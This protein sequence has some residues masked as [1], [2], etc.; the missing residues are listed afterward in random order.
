MVM[1]FSENIQNSMEYANHAFKSFGSW[2]VLI[3]LYAVMFAGT[4]LLIVGTIFMLTTLFAVLTPEMSSMIDPA[5]MMNGPMMDDPALGMLAGLSV[6]FSILGTI[7]TIITGIFIYGVTMRV[8]RGGELVMNNWGKMFVEGL[9]GML[10]LF[11]YMIPYTILS[12]LVMFGPIDNMAYLIIVGTIIPLIILF[13][14]MM[15]GMMAVIKFAKE[16]NL[17]AAFNFKELFSLIANI[18]WLRY[19]G[20]WIL[21]SLIVG[22]AELILLCI[23][24]AGIILLVVALPFIMIVMSRFFANLYDSALPKVTE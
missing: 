6:V 14:S 11:I 22:V 20:Y 12:F 7:V 18:G 19:L 13:I 23:P 5:M 1:N 9:L 3:F 10:I 4:V 24:I 17:G 16:G 2:F 21:L 8:F 15:V